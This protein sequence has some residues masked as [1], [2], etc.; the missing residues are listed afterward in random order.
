MR[1]AGAPSQAQRRPANVFALLRQLPPHFLWFTRAACD[2]ARTADRK[3][4]QADR[5]RLS[6]SQSPPWSGPGPTHLAD[7]FTAARKDRETLGG[8]ARLA[9]RK[10]A[11]VTAPTISHD[12]IKQALVQAGGSVTG[13]ARTLGIAS[14]NLRELVRVHPML[15]DAVFEQIEQEIDAAWQVLLD[16]LRSDKA[17]TRTRA[18]A[19]ILRHTDAGRRRGWGRSRTQRRETAEPQDVT[20]KW[21]D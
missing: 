13:A 5:C 18:A 6:A 9:R 10:V 11:S 15:A 12:A 16:G 4:A 7:V 8:A 17:M 1:Q 14:A 3:I 19:Y 2:S 21:I 20:I